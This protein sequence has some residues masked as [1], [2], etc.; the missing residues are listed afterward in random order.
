MVENIRMPF[1]KPTPRPPFAIR[2]K[3][4]SRWLSAA[5]NRD[6]PLHAIL[7]LNPRQA[8]R[9]CRNTKSRRTGSRWG[10][11]LIEHCHRKAWGIIEIGWI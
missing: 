1:H 8:K 4:W 6:V 9:P 5:F 11:F 7:R 10:N 2:T 3:N